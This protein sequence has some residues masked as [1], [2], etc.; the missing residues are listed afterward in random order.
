MNLS[1]RKSVYEMSDQEIERELKDFAWEYVA[2]ADWA[3]S[4]EQYDAGKV[5]LEERE[6]DLHLQ[7][8]LRA[9]SSQL[10]MRPADLPTT[11]PEGHGALVVDGDLR[12]CMICKY[13][14]SR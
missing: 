4:D 13:T 9:R 1:R 3:R 10:T 6:L 7:Q 14:V 5:Y 8:E 2:L 12:F 11:C